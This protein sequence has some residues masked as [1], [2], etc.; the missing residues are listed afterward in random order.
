MNINQL[1]HLMKIA[2]CGSITEAAEQLYIS[3]PSLSKSIALLEKEYGIQLLDR[4]PNGVSLTPIGVKFLNYSKIV[5]EA[6]NSL[7]NM[8]S[9]RNAEARS[10]LFISAQQFDFLYDLLLKTIG[11]DN[12]RSVFCNI[13]ETDRSTVIRRVIEGEVDIGIAVRTNS[14]AKSFLW[15][16]DIKK[17]DIYYLDRAG[18]YACIGPKSQFY[19][20]Q[21]ITFSEAESCPQIAL[22]I[23][24]EAKLNY[25]FNRSKNHFN[26]NNIT[27]FNSIY[28]CEH[29]LLETDSLLYISKWT[30]GCFLGSPIRSVEVVSDHDGDANLTT[31]LI[32]IKRAGEPLNRITSQFV[33]NLESHFN[34]EK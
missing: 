29:F 33:N 23:E 10:Q 5:L 32:W 27:F 12:I 9:D 17:L 18:V 15:Q 2:D 21:K 4:K 30:I 34:M 8:F 26:K 24:P 25:F 14:D 16:T 19:H 28:A 1:R 6:A 3:Q 31:E 7:D 20:R 13:V 22:D 11:N